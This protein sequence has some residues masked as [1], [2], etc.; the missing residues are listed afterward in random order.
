LFWPA[1][2]AEVGSVVAGGVESAGVAMVAAFLVAVGLALLFGVR[3]AVTL[4]GLALGAVDTLALA[5]GDALLPVGEGATVSPTWT[6]RAAGLSEL[7]LS[8]AA[9]AL[10]PAMTTTVAAMAHVC[11]LIFKS[12]SPHGCWR[13]LHGTRH[14]RH[15]TITSA[16]GHQHPVDRRTPWALSAPSTRT[17]RSSRCSGRPATARP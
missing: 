17:S 10:P 15:I 4:L 1:V 2:A 5:D 7:L 14:R 13:A 11:L 16:Q 12:T 9:V 8:V 3:L 6:V